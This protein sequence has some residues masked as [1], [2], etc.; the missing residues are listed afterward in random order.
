MRFIVDARASLAERCAR[1]DH[2]GTAGLE[3]PRFVVVAEGEGREFTAAT[4]GTLFCKLNEPPGELA[5]N[6]GHVT[7]E[8]EPK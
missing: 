4:D 7:V 5:D 8:I 1:L 3:R 6:N 2:G